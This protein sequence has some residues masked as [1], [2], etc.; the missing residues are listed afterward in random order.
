MPPGNAE[1][2]VHYQ[3]TIRN[4]VAFDRIAPHLSSALAR[5][6]QQIFGLNPIAVWGSRDSPANRARFDRMVE[7]D[8]IL[9]VEGKTI[10][11]LGRIA[12]KL[13][14]PSLSAKLWKNLR[15]D[16]TEGWNLIYFIANPREIDLPFA[17]FCRLFE[18]E[19][20]FQLHGLTSIAKEGLQ[21]V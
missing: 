15:G 6:L 18:Y 8:E 9:I 14:S 2:M 7:G 12:G 11:L 20:H 4:K 21:E 1:A 13:I 10:K 17:E 19:E 16:T 5:K 3:D